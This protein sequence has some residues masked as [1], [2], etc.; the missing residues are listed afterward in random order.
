MS[1]L[2]VL[3]CFKINMGLGEVFLSKTG[4]PETIN[5]KNGQIFIKIKAF[6]A[7]KNKYIYNH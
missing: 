1:W 5:L 2:L 7:R 4:N 6:C 3:S